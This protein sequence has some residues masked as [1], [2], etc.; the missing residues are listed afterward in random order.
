MACPSPS[1]GFIVASTLSAGCCSHPSSLCPHSIMCSFTEILAPCTRNSLARCREARLTGPDFP[2]FSILQFGSC[3]AVTIMAILEEVPDDEA[4]A[5]RSTT[6]AHCAQRPAVREVSQPQAAVKQEGA[7]AP[8]NMTPVN[9]A[10]LMAT[11]RILSARLALAADI[12][13]R[14]MRAES[15]KCISH[16]YRHRC[17]HYM[18]NGYRRPGGPQVPSSSDRYGGPNLTGHRGGIRLA[19][20]RWTRRGGAS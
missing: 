5:V 11:L 17:K 7:A 10:E 15:G 18:A 6:T 8:L 4:P 9:Q 3:I 13:P 20:L 16:Y 1:A 19:A 12:L 14:F 2:F